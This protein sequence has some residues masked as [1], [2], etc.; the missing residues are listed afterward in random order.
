MP[1]MKMG[2]ARVSRKDQHLEAKRD[3]L[4]TDG[5]ERVFEEKMSSREAFDCC[6]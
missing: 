6:T 1:T 4:L 5:C 2:Y 3:A